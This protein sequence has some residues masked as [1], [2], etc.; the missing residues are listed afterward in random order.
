MV[1]DCRVIVEAVLAI[2]GTNPCDNSVESL[3]RAVEFAECCS[4]FGRYDLAAELLDIVDS[5]PMGS[6]EHIAQLAQLQRERI[7]NHDSIKTPQSTENVV[8]PLTIRGL[9]FA[10]AMFRWASS[11]M[12]RRTQAEID[13]R[14]AI[15]QACP[16]FVDNHCQVCGCPCVET[17]QLINKLAL[18]TEACPLGKWK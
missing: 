16:H 14:L 11:G 3:S 12:P 9:N 6:I 2:R 10:S 15:C 4:L 17:N 7:A 5:F 1:T 8:P 18:A 13:E